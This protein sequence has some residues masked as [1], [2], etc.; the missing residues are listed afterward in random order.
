MVIIGVDPHPGTHTA[1]AL[2]T[3]GKE[4]A[5]LTIENNEAG[6]QRLRDWA[7]QFPERVWAI[8]GAN[9]SFVTALSHALAVQEEV[10]NISPNLTSQYRSRKGRKKNDKVDAENVARA[11]LANPDLPSFA[12]QPVVEELKELTRTRE[13]L[14]ETLKANRS[15]LRRLSKGTTSYQALEAVVACLE[16]Q[17]AA[18]EADMEGLVKASALQLL[19]LRGVATVNA[20]VILAEAGDAER[21][22]D[23]H[24]FASYVG[25]APIERSSG[26]QKRRQLDPGGNRRL[27]RT[28]HLIALVRLRTDETTQAYVTRK[29]EEGKTFR[30]ALRSLKTVIAREL[31]RYLK[32]SQLHAVPSLGPCS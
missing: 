25:C 23:Q 22:R 27:K 8:E 32:T 20:A 6:L 4:L 28:C 17:I 30:A 2:D 29:Q 3:N 19:T 1:V 24:A 16:Q 7:E 9:N 14:A 5:H 10:V 26:G 13:R 21:F 31:Y 18:L 15:A 11:Y 12:P